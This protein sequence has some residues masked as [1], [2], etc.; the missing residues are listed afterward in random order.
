MTLGDGLLVGMRTGIRAD[1]GGVTVR[2]HHHGRVICRIERLTAA[3][4]SLLLSLPAI[5]AAGLKE[6]W[7]FRHEIAAES[8]P[9][10]V[11][12]D[13]R[14]VAGLATIDW[15]L[16]FLRNHPTY[17]FIAYRIAVGI[18]IL[19]LASSGIIK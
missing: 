19:A 15:L 11:H 4:F 3:R 6:G 17:V 14:F 18:A 5:A 2:Y 1:S 10:N 16:K 7:D 8:C 12:R 13:G 9:P